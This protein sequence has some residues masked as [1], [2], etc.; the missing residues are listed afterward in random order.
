MF[1]ECEAAIGAKAEDE[2]LAMPDDGDGLGVAAGSSSSTDLPPSA[3]VLPPAPV[4]SPDD[5]VL[6]CNQDGRG[7]VTC[8]AAPWSELG[9]IAR[10]TSWPEHEPPDRRSVSVKC[11]MHK[12]KCAIVRRRR[13]FSDNQLMRWV[14]EGEILAHGCS[15]ERRRQLGEDH[16]KAWSSLPWGAPKAGAVVS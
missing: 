7:I 6:A 13:N 15:Q 2:L 12:G 5:A 3:P 4:A 11:L 8:V 1:D 9:H 16:V 14:L 10:I